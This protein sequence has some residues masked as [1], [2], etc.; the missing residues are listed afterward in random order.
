M[1]LAEYKAW[2][3]SDEA[4][5]VLVELDYQYQ[6]GIGDDAVPTTGT[7]HYSNK[8]F[9]DEEA[10]PPR[11]YDPVL[12]GVP[13]IERVLERESLRGAARVNVS[14]DFVFNNADR[15]QNHLL[16]KAIDGS[17]ARIYIGSASWA[18][19]DF[20]GPFTVYMA[21]AS[22]A[23]DRKKVEISARDVGLLLNKRIGGT[24]TIGG[25]GPNAEKF[26]PLPFGYVVNM[27][28][29]LVETSPAFKYRYADRSTN[30]SVPIVRSNGAALTVTTEYVDNGGTFDLV[31][32]PQGDQITCDV[33]LYG[34]GKTAVDYRISDALEFFIGGEAGL[35]ALG[36]Y[37]GAHATYF[38]SGVTDNPANDYFCGDVLTEP[39]N[40][41]AW[42]DRAMD[43]ANGH[44]APTREGKFQYGRM[45]PEALSAII[46]LSGGRLTVS[47][48]LG[49]GDFVRD[50]LKVDHAL[51]GYASYQPLARLNRTQQTTFAGA[52]TADERN[53]LEREGLPGE[54]FGGEEPGTTQ[55]LGSLPGEPYKGGAPELYHK[56]LVGVEVVRTLISGPDDTSAPDP[57]GDPT[58]DMPTMC[59]RWASVRRARKLPWTEFIDGETFFVVGNDPAT[60]TPLYQLE[61]AD[62]INLTLPDFD[63]ESGA[64]HQ[65]YRIGFRF[66][67]KRMML[68]VCRR[69]YAGV[70]GPLSSKELREDG[71]IE[72][73]EDGDREYRE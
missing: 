32:N 66:M 20:I 34:A 60:A 73:R 40:A 31:N 24:I 42:L 5:C 36:L 23:N 29:V 55:Y 37:A 63:L 72:L 11:A 59:R 18:R 22:A 38:D 28:P 25:T 69:R 6:V 49:V 1:T 26:A 62:I 14:G 15:R 17:P 51:P 2:F 39:T 47:A 71:G 35:T 12:L 41:I 33:L 58:N 68:G 21:K 67:R 57:V 19:S 56:S 43:T 4:P 54:G 10:D 8:D 9:I 7:L 27:A 65:V 53:A 3:R 52:L 70:S 30:A 61:L 16:Y 45:R 44:W 48:E 64:L 13:D 46:A 50:S